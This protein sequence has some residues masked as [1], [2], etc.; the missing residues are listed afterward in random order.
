MPRD[1]SG[2]QDRVVRAASDLGGPRPL[3]RSVGLG[4]PVIVLFALPGLALLFQPQVSTL[5]IGVGCVICFAALLATVWHITGQRQDVVWRPSPIVPHPCPVCSD[6]ARWRCAEEVSGLGMWD[7]D[8]E[9]DQI[10]CSPHWRRMLGSAEGLIWASLDD[11][12]ARVHPEDRAGLDAASRRWLD[13]DVSA[14]DIEYRILT[15]DGSYRWI[16]ARGRLI[17]RTPDG[18]PKRLIG[19]GIDVT[20]RKRA[21]TELQIAA[22]VFDRQDGILITDA[23]EVILRVNRACLD[24]TGYEREELIG[25]TPRLFKS[26]RHDGGFYAAMWESLQRTGSWHGEVW[27]RRKSG[28]IYPEWLTITALKGDAGQVTHYVAT[29]HDISERKAAE[30]AILNLA[31]F[32]ALTG[33]PNRRLLLDRLEHALVV[34]ERSRRFG[35]LLFIDLDHFKE[36]ND[37]LGHAVGD[38]LLQEVARRLRGAVRDVDTVARL[39]GDEFV[40][41]LEDLSGEAGDAEVRAADVGTKILGLLDQSYQLGEHGYDSTPSIGIVLFFGNKTGTDVL[42]SRA[43]MA[44]YRAKQSGRNALRF[45]DPTMQAS[46][47]ERIALKEDLRQGVGR[48]EFALHY[49]PQVDRA[50]DVVGVEALLRWSRPEREQLSPQEFIPIAEECGLILPLGHW[51]LES[52]CSQLEAWSSRPAWSTLTLSINISPRQFRD[53]S[54]VEQVIEVLERTG[55]DPTRLQLELDERLLLSDPGPIL[56]RMEALRARGVRFSLD[57]FGVG[58][59]SLADLRGLPLSQLKL[60]QSFVRDL[61]KDAK[62]AAITRNVIV[63]GRELGLEVIAAGVETEAQRAFLQAHHCHG[64]QGYLFGRPLRPDQ[65]AS[66][67]PRA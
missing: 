61:G 9:S 36:L 31:F 33:L 14:A 45:F 2:C 41:M 66:S 37:T 48:Q 29:L 12:R 11:W 50:G 24:I 10:Y 20:E 63:L 35:A 13:G 32:D 22:K 16:L 51:V 8:L 52:A 3:V 17:E 34:S 59:S 6:G 64:Y 30:E 46:V 39:G 57:H 7:W 40:V 56:A 15:P 58:Y 5:V 53:T 18:A 28:E 27:N 23:D 60:D 38:L 43:D 1:W 44:M 42:L 47:D 25:Q 67:G 21:E 19:V 4:I 55:A 65:F 54:F 62:A 26:G 49:Q